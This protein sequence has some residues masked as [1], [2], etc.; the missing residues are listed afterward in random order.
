[1]AAL[2]SPT[3][4]LQG[5]V[6]DAKASNIPERDAEAAIGRSNA[7]ANRIPQQPTGGMMA[8]GLRQYEPVN[9]P[10][11]GARPGSG[12]PLNDPNDSYGWRNPSNSANGYYSEVA[13]NRLPPG[14]APYDSYA[15]P[16]PSTGGGLFSNLNPADNAPPPAAPL[17]GY[18]QQNTPPDPGLI[19]AMNSARDAPAPAP[20]SM[21]R[22]AA[23]QAPQAQQ[24]P[25][26]PVIGSNNMF[27]GGSPT[28]DESAGG[29][30]IPDTSAFFSQ[31]LR[32][33]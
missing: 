14:M 8:S 30:S 33:R 12:G 32:G 20:P 4:A 24:A 5:A 11:A 28:F 26:A 10:S 2:L 9:M 21:P 27:A 16:P 22:D 17:P 18:V 3:S 31:A 19:A 13:G 15:P 7:P 29:Q 23:P 1:M 25:Q 6:A